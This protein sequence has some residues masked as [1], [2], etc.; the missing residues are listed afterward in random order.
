[1]WQKKQKLWMYLVVGVALLT[2]CGSKAAGAD[3]QTLKITIPGEP[4]TVD[5][6]KSIETNGGAIIDQISEGI[7]KRDRNNKIVPGMVE[8]IV[9]PT[10]N[11]TKYTFK[12]KKNARW[13]DGKPVTAQDFVTSLVR[14]T[15]PKTK[16]QATTGV[17]YIQNFKA[18]NTGKMDPHK[19][20]V[21]AI[22]QRTFSI[23]LTKP[24]PFINY[25]FVGYK[26]V[27]TAA[28]KKYGEKYGTNDQTTVANGP[29]T[30]KGWNGNNDS[31]HYV[32]NKYYWN[33]KHVQIAKVDV[34]VVKDDNTAQS[35][36]KSGSVD[37]TNVSGQ[38][39]KQ[40]RNSKEL[41]V[42]PTGRNNYIY[43]NSKRTATANENLRHAISLVINRQQLANKVLQDGSRPA[44]N[45]VPKN[46]AKD[47]KTGRDFI[48]EVGNLAPTDV[49]QAKQYW[50]KAQRDLGKSK[51]T[52]DFLVD[53]VDTEKKLAE[54]VQGAVQKNLPGLKIN[55]V[56]VPHATHVS[57]DFSC[58]FD[59]CTV[60][61]GP[62]Y[63]DAQN[64]LDGMRSNNQ[65]NFAKTKDDQYDALM[66]KV[67][68]T[69]TYSAQQRWEFEKQADQRLM[70]IA[71]VAPTYQAAQA[72]FVNSKLG[73]L[74]WDAMSGNS[75]QLQYAYWK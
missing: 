31:W 38:F 20:G 57:R 25:I 12:I 40:N 7:Y 69:T 3:N 64:F 66:D 23:T 75:G 42:T 1:M 26:P 17:Q 73:G 53:D 29:Y 16:S 44:T 70:Q 21:K 27:Q 74:K 36:F 14:T 56:S 28:I 68:D 9:Q 6:N 8:K 48:D 51:V 4:M 50:Q 19:L 37:L 71:G 46:Y 24:I 58:D 10:E 65:I 30:L 47:P 72:H 18:I 54:Y 45:I 67:S 2:G 62:D 33:A 32:K 34:N 41:V 5:P 15:D 22:D 52:L 63:P 60:G 39:V 61:W 13:Q 11:G 35:M 59:I 43:F 55:I 49:N